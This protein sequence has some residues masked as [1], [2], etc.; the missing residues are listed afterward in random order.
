MAE[1]NEE[2]AADRVLS[3]EEGVAIK[4]RVT[5]KKALKTWRW[6]GNFGDPAEAAAVANSNPPCLAGEVIFTINGSLT[7][8]WMFF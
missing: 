7:P 2:I 4:Q 8:A 5:A 3:V 1:Q 6:M